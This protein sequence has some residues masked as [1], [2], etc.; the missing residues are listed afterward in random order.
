MYFV[1]RWNRSQ[2]LGLREQSFVR[3]DIDTLLV[4]VSIPVGFD[5]T[6]YRLGSQ[7]L[8]GTVLI[9]TGSALGPY[10]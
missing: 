1:Q 9:L 8:P 2:G 7:S 3:Y 5:I 10:W 4:K 6:T